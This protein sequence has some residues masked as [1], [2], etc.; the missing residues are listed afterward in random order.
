MLTTIRTWSP[1]VLKFLCECINNT[2]RDR[3]RLR[4]CGR[5]GPSAFVFRGDIE[6]FVL[7][8]SKIGGLCGY[9]GIFRAFVQ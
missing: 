2:R 5:A 1:S 9:E 7:V 3:F 6:F 4:R 8:V